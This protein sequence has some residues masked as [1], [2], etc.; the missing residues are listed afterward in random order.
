MWKVFHTKTTN[1]EYLG[2][3]K[4]TPVLQEDFKIRFA[5]KKK[6]VHA[7]GSLY[8]EMLYIWFDSPKSVPDYI[9]IITDI[10]IEFSDT[11]NLIEFTHFSDDYR[12]FT[13]LL[14]EK[15]IYQHWK[16]ILTNYSS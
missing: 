8:I 2:F 15:V 14:E 11:E 16:D 4:L 7:H 10:N 5:G 6:F 3:H 9:K 12:N 13:I 1:R